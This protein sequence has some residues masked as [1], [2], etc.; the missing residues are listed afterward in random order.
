MERE[1]EMIEKRHERERESKIVRE[2]IEKQTER[3]DE[4]GKMARL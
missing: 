4:Q 3:D 1:R 2:M